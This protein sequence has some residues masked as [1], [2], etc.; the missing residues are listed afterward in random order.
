MFDWRLI[1][2]LN[3]ALLAGLLM[4]L[5]GHLV[6]ETR[7]LVVLGRDVVI[8]VEFVPCGWVSD[9]LRLSLPCRADFLSHLGELQFVDVLAF[10]LRR[11]LL[12]QPLEYF[13]LL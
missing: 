11:R 4:L 1:V 2:D 8:L 12:V 9:S 10:V 3:L 6:V 13:R 5:L 7:R